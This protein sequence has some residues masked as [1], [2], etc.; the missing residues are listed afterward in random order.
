[1]WRVK[2]DCELDVSDDPNQFV[3]H[4]EAMN[5]LHD[6]WFTANHTF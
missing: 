5:I 6:R 2:Q 4:A 1:M 3:A